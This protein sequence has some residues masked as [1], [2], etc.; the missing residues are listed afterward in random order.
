MNSQ[1]CKCIGCLFIHLYEQRGS[2][3]VVQ[4]PCVGWNLKVVVLHVKNFRIK[5]SRPFK[6]KFYR[7]YNFNDN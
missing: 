2:V 5:F 1:K 4:C 3:F 6:G 7:Y